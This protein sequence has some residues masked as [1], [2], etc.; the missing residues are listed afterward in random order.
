MLQENLIKMYEASF[1]KHHALT[2][3]TDYFSKDSKTY[4]Q[5]AEQIARMHVLFAAVAL[6]R[7]G[8]GCRVAP[9]RALER[10]VLHEVCHALVGRVFVA[11]AGADHVAAIHYVR[12]RALANEAQAVGQDVCIVSHWLCF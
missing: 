9:C 1:R 10:K 3:L 5:M 8:C 11:R 7:T 6:V 12:I 2:A 4:F